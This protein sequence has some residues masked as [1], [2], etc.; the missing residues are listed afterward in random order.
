MFFTNKRRLSKCILHHVLSFSVFRECDGPEEN[1]QVE[2]YTAF[3][4]IF[5][6]FFFQ[7]FLFTCKKQLFYIERQCDSVTLH[8]TGCP[9]HTKKKG[10]VG[11]HVY[12]RKY[13]LK[14][15]DNGHTTIHN[16]F[17]VQSILKYPPLHS[18]TPSPPHT[19]THPPL[20]LL[21]CALIRPPRF[22][23]VCD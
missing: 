11:P 8:R 4:F 15:L 21:Q 14:A 6:Q 9:P 23:R 3:L 2:A 12:V 1:T 5:L 20:L 17:T 7:C 22:K 13:N 10:N 18:Y 16:T 19:H